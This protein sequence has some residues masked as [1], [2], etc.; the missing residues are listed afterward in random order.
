M[1]P[2]IV[3]VALIAFTLLAAYLPTVQAG[4]ERRSSIRLQKWQFR[5]D[6]KGKG[7]LTVRVGN[8]GDAFV[9]WNDVSTSPGMWQTVG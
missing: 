2:R 4:D 5:R 6:A 9:N 7:I 3:R 8:Y 1:L